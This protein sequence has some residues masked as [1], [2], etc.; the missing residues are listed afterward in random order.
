MLGTPTSTFEELQLPL[1]ELQLQLPLLGLQLHFLN[2]CTWQPLLDLLLWNFTN[3]E[4]VDL[5]GT[6]ATVSAGSMDTY[7]FCLGYDTLIL[8]IFA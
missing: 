6:P 2:Y 1:S 3:L 4:H 5:Q 7:E 8:G